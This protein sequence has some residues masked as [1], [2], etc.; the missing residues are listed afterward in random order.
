MGLTHSVMPS[1]FTEVVRAVAP[2]LLG[3]WLNY[4]MSAPPRGET[5]PSEFAFIAIG[6]YAG[7]GIALA[8]WLA[9]G[10]GSLVSRVA[11]VGILWLAWTLAPWATFSASSPKPFGADRMGV[12]VVSSFALA[13]GSPP[14]AIVRQRNRLIEPFSYSARSEFL[15][16]TQAFF[17]LCIA[18]VIAGAC[19]S[20]GRYLP[21]DLGSALVIA[22]VLGIV[23]CVA[24]PLFARGFL[25]ES[26]RPR[27][28]LL[29]S[30]LPVAIALVIGLFISVPGP[31][32][33]PIH[34]VGPAALAAFSATTT[35]ITAFV[36]WRSLGLRTVA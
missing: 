27:E 7:E 9:W 26:V 15:R 21:W 32:T 3:M 4:S 1:R 22:V 28:I 13:L 5:P 17:L 16:G 11:T 35:L 19:Y 24:A 29:A 8:L 10:P 18:L 12:I 25:R 31:G 2:L 36:Y 30:L 34:P 20:R 14:L 6:I 23:A 33:A